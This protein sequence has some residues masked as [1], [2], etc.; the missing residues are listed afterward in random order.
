MAVFTQTDFLNEFYFYIFYDFWGFCLF[1]YFCSSSRG[2][3]DY[4]YCYCNFLVA[5]QSGLKIC[6][7][8]TLVNSE[9]NKLKQQYRMTGT[10]QTAL[11]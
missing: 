11:N 1:I 3:I 7:H 6:R 10:R 4:S 9:G 8:L 5:T 2:P